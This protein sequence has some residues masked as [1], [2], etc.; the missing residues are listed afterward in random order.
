[1]LSA[2]VFSFCTSRVCHIVFDLEEHSHNKLGEINKL[3]AQTF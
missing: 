2:A 1:M 3:D